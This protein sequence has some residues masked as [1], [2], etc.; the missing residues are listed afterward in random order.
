MTKYTL[1]LSQK[2]FDTSCLFIKASE[3]SCYLQHIPV[4][5]LKS[6]CFAYAE[7]ITNFG[8]LICLDLFSSPIP[9]S[10]EA[11]FPVK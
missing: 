10:T 6:F 8:G 7:A 9:R 4:T 1:S 11:G 3:I 2:R 5:I